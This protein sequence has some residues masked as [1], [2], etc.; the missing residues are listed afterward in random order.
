MTGPRIRIFVNNVKERNVILSLKDLTNLFDEN[1]SC[2]VCHIKYTMKIS[3]ETI[4]IATELSLA[5]KNP[6]CLE[7]DH[8]SVMEPST[9]NLDKLIDHDCDPYDLKQTGNRN[10]RH[11]Q[12]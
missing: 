4:G 5:C 9:V 3:A 8:C 10:T 1:M 11:Y 12:L 2:G 6:L 7:H